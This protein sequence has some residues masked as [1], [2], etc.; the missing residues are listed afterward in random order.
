MMWN[1]AGNR[2]W[3]PKGR[4]KPHARDN[5]YSHAEGGVATS[6]SAF[7]AFMGRANAWLRVSLLFAAC[8]TAAGVS[9]A[10]VTAPG[11][12]IRNVGSVAYE[13]A[14]GAARTT[15]SNEVSLAVQ[16]LPSRSSIQLARYE[17]SASSAYTA[18]PTQCRA[19]AEPISRI[20]ASPAPNGRTC[21][22]SVST[23]PPNG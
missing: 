7:G 21:C 10:Q 6:Y 3:R 9:E 13:V 15:Q 20:A 5:G 1:A 14:P 11:T 17:A 2:A 16:P 4:P 22:A 23:R 12:V 19:G 18:G 8:L